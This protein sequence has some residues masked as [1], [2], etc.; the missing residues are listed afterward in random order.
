[1]NPKIGSEVLTVR[2]S[3]RLRNE[4]DTMSQPRELLSSTPQMANNTQSIIQVKCSDFPVAASSQL[5]GSENLIVG[6]R[7]PGR[8]I[9]A[10]RQLLDVAASRTEP[11]AKRL[12]CV[13]G[14]S[15]E[16]GFVSSVLGPKPAGD[17]EAIKAWVKDRNNLYSRYN[18]MRKYSLGDTKV[19]F[20]FETPNFP[21]SKIL[22][23]V[24]PYDVMATLLLTLKCNPS[25][26]ALRARAV[27]IS[28]AKGCWYYPLHRGPNGYDDIQGSQWEDNDLLDG[29]F[30]MRLASYFQKIS[31]TLSNHT[32]C[33][34]YRVYPSYLE[35]RVPCHQSMHLDDDMAYSRELK[36]SVYILHV[37]LTGQGRAMRVLPDPEQRDLERMI[38]TPFGRGTVLRGDLYHAGCY[39]SK[40]NCGLAV[41]FIP[42]GTEVNLYKLGN[43][44]GKF[45]GRVEPY[46]VHQLAWDARKSQ[47]TGRV[48]P[49]EN[50]TKGLKRNMPYLFRHGLD[51][52]EL[53]PALD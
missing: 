35:T 30:V 44:P 38:H 21:D 10:S 47:S 39:G 9:A 42:V 13:P 51:P 33:K 7:T 14:K 12:K 1:M 22:E 15:D 5:A 11:E 6:N 34:E 49:S 36:E 29:T 48:C 50:Y 24:I 46:E 23:L 18:R 25:S 31:D 37:P 41:K 8:L 16:D 53:L 28:T 40:G 27:P 3:N 20:F 2:R 52:T 45:P 43:L 32:G 17:D 4:S 19:L 26:S